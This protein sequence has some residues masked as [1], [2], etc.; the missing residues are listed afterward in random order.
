[1]DEVLELIGKEKHKNVE[2][3]EKKQT[4]LNELD[5]LNDQLKELAE[6]IC[7]SCE[8]DDDDDQESKEKVSIETL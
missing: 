2:L 1:L 6:R 5:L 4:V 7:T 8:S 3:K